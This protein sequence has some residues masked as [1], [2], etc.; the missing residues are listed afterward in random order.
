MVKQTLSF[1]H[2]SRSQSWLI[3]AR[4]ACDSF[5]SCQLLTGFRSCADVRDEAD[6]GHAHVGVALHPW[7]PVDYLNKF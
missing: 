7:D 6:G 2:Q 3:C 5:V 4:D 1:T